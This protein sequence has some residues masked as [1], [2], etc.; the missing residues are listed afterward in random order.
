MSSIISSVS[1]DLSPFQALDCDAVKKCKSCL[2]D[3]NLLIQQ[4]NDT[5]N[6][7][8]DNVYTPILGKEFNLDSKRNELIQSL[9]ELE[10]LRV[11]YNEQFNGVSDKK[12][13]LQLLNKQLS[14]FDIFAIYDEYKKQLD[15][16]KALK[17]KLDNLISEMNKKKKTLDDL[18]Q[19]K[20][21]IKI[22]VAAINQGLQ[23]VFFSNKRLQ[24][25]VKD[26]IY[27][28]ASNGQAVRPSDISSGERNI[29][30]LCYFFVDIMKNLDKDK[31]YEQECFLV[32]DDPV[33]SFDLENRIGILSFLKS[34]LLKILCGNINSK[35]LIMTH[36]LPTFYDMEKIMKE[37]MKAANAIFGS[38]FTNYSIKELTQQTL[39]EF[40][41]KK[42]HEYTE[43]VSSVFNYANGTAPEYDM[44]I[45]NVMRRTMEAFS[46]FEYKQGMDEIS[47]DEQ[48]LNSLGNIVYHD[49]F[50]NLMYRLLLNG[51]S[52]MEERVKSLT[53]PLFATNVSEAEKT[54]T[55]KDII[56]F[57]YLLNKPHVEAHLK[58]IPTA[59]PTIQSWC[60]DI[61]AI[62]GVTESEI[63]SPA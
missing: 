22:A 59:I 55:A 56:C 33:S 43:L 39:I 15:E 60:N 17:E 21:S 2:D 26:E 28:L 14:Y 1:F 46:T 30:A 63:K 3:L 9:K 29:I 16:K 20:K 52:H 61:L 5:L 25:T 8:A 10:V 11:K 13:H 53:D 32:I 44:V 50:Q 51:D 35:V 49:Y 40:R 19:Q 48:I 23:Y 37:I 57:M 47:C 36:D 41:E 6:Q 38:N 27:S 54:R 24:I 18:L 58:D 42:R 7:K 62:V 4:I 31:A 34:K 12:K 45:G